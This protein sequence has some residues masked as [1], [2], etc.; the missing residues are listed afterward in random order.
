MEEALILSKLVHRRM[1]EKTELIKRLHNMIVA[2]NKENH[3]LRE[4]LKTL[5][6]GMVCQSC[7]QKTF[8]NPNGSGRFDII[9][10]FIYI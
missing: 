5:K 8:I 3:K 1:N 10:H 2:L 7:N 6:N 9:L 4:H